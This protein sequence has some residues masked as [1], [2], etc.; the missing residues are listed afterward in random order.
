M[1][2]I[3]SYNNTQNTPAE[4][5]FLNTIPFEFPSEPITC[6]F[7][8]EDVKGFHLKQISLVNRPVDI[9][10]IFPG[11]GNGELVYTSFDEKHEGMIPLQV[12]FSD[13]KNYYFAKRWYNG[14]INHY[15]KSHGFP[16]ETNRITNDNQIWVYDRNGNKRKDCW[17]FD[18]FT[19]KIDW[20]DFNKHPQLVLSYDRPTLVYKKSVAQLLERQSDPFEQDAEEGFTL[21]LVK[22]IY[23]T[24]KR[25]DGKDAYRIDRYEYLSNRKNFDNKNAYPI[26]WPRLADFIGIPREDDEQDDT[27]TTR[28]RRIENR[29]K[30]YYDKINFFYNSFLNNDEFRS[31]IEID[32]NGFAWATKMQIGRTASSCQELVFGGGAI[33]FNPQLGINN[34]PLEEPKQTNIQLMFIFHQDD[35][36]PARDL[37]KFFLREGY[38][39][40]FKGLSKYTGKAVTS[41]PKAYHLQFQN[42]ENPVPEIELFLRNL[43]KEEGVSYLAIYLTPHSKHTTDKNAREIYYHV[44]KMLMDAGIASQCIETEKM[45]RILEDDKGTD[46]KGRELKNFAYTLQNMAIAIN[47]KLGGIPWRIRTDHYDELVV[48]VGA[49]RTEDGTCYIGSAFSFDNDGIF[50]SFNYFL[51]DE[52]EELAGSIEEAIINFTSAKGL[53]DRLI[54]HYYKTIREDEKDIIEDRL[55]SLNLDIPVYIISINK[56]ESEDK[57][58]FDSG[59]SDMMPY[60]GRYVNLGAKRFLLCNNT[61][62]GEKFNPY[63]GFPFPVKLR[64]DTINEENDPDS[65]TT[66]ELIE[67]VYQFSRIY[68]KSVKQQNLPVTIKYPEMVAEMAPHF[69]GDCIPEEFEN[70]LWFL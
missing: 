49:F 8:K 44:K 41:A 58:L 61:R 33:D 56:T 67:Q 53:P 14:I 69:N 63:D 34:G 4:K 55:H 35:I 50:N 68:W 38:K 39:N 66:K 70:R 30:K 15:F 60:S 5:L 9:N 13:H 43:C 51:K 2:Y 32:K 24:Y 11:L 59:T 1:A 21:S 29:Y 6:W 40:F 64:I 54:I 46:N 20:D 7:S 42:R 10:S 18:R 62:Y 31:K 26:M 22:R 23:F 25:E 65:V 12:N 28:K 37:L 57:V 36:A 17:Q 45:L 52:M 48:G 47:A 27:Y 16:V 19:L 3:K